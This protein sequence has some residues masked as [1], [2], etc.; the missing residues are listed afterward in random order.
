VVQARE[1]SLQG[2]AG[3]TRQPSF[4]ASH[5][6]KLQSAT[7]S[8]RTH[9]GGRRATCQRRVARSHLAERDTV[10]AQERFTAAP[11]ALSGAVAEGVRDT[12]PGTRSDGAV[13]RTGPRIGSGAKARGVSPRRCGTRS[14]DVGGQLRWRSVDGSACRLRAPIARRRTGVQGE[15]EQDRG[16]ARRPDLAPAACLLTCACITP[17]SVAA[18]GPLL[19]G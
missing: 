7:M 6:A 2:T 10:V 15:Q 8:V 16:G 5:V 4:R 3:S 14:P 11:E 1:G 13:R 17:G 9:G 19:A 12:Q 18:A